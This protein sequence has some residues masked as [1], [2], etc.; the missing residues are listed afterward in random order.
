MGLIGKIGTWVIREACR[1]A[2][3]WPEHLSISV[4]LSPIQFTGTVRDV[5]AAALIDAGLKPQQLEVEITESLLLRDTG[6]VMDD[7]S[8]AD[9]PTLTMAT[10]NAGYPSQPLTAPGRESDDGHGSDGSSDA[11]QLHYHLPALRPAGN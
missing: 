7:D 8:R 6:A 10:E 3:T 4:N 9:I 2:A 1:V 11:T 5:V